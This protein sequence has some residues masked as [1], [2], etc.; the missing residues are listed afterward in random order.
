MQPVQKSVV[1]PEL[2]ETFHEG[3]EEVL[4]TYIPAVTSPVDVVFK[5]LYSFDLDSKEGLMKILEMLAVLDPDIV[6]ALAGR[7][8][9]G[10]PTGERDIHLLRDEIRG[11]I[12][13][14]LQPS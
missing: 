8:W 2:T 9:P 7:L 10:Y 5:S 1:I 12:I 4:G 6:R 3:A 14:A 13:D 11:I